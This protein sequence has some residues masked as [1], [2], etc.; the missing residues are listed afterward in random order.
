MSVRFSNCPLYSGLASRKWHLK[1]K[2]MVSSHHG[3]VFNYSPIRADSQYGSKASP[4]A[5]LTLSN[6]SKCL[7]AQ[8]TSWKPRELAASLGRPDQVFWLKQVTGQTTNAYM[9]TLSLTCSLELE[10]D[11]GNWAR[12]SKNQHLKT[13]REERRKEIQNQ[14][15]QREGIRCAYLFRLHLTRCSG[16]YLFLYCV[17]DVS[18]WNDYLNITGCHG[19]SHGEIQKAPH[20]SS[21]LGY[22]TSENEKKTCKQLFSLLFIYLLCVPVWGK[23]L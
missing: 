3:A 13:R 16:K 23:F 15:I 19:Q 17:L 1:V 7:P 4:E 20:H 12:C 8:A 9:A 6:P 22:S 21:V 18:N 11:I 5:Q 10:M 14:Q 2:V